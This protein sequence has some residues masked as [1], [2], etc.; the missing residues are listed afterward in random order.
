[1]GESLSNKEEKI[2]AEKDSLDILKNKLVTVSK[3]KEEAFQKMKE[4]RQKIVS[5][6]NKI[7]EL[8]IAR[9]KL[10]KDVQV[11]KKE[12]NVLNSQVKEKSNNK[13]EA[14][15]R[16]K[17]LKGSKENPNGI[18]REI[19]LLEEKIETEVMP[20]SKEQALT[21]RIKELKAKFK[22]L[23]KAK[24]AWKEVKAV[25]SDFLEKRE[26]AEICHAQVQEKAK[27]SQSKHEEIKKLFLEIK[28]LRK[29]EKPISMVYQKKKEE[30]INLKQQID[31]KK[32]NLKT[33][34]EKVNQVL[35]DNFDKKVIKKTEQVQ[36]K[37]R[38][39][40]KLST[41]DILAFQAL[42]S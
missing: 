39:G 23:D 7:N 16:K 5:S 27:A 30:F 10:T 2:L 12:R 31:S 25:T 3:E 28:N 26:K 11:L 35:K 8:K 18:A 24:E 4:I 42:K 37:M 40:K 41:E 29:E 32:N 15:L 22:E 34:S 36:E 13:K 1:M 14:E 33:M 21:K 9:D 19:K 20:F 17:G 6:R 38:Q